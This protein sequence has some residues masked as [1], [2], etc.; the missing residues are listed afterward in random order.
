MTAGL[1]SGLGRF[2][3]DD[4]SSKW[5]SLS[6]AAVAVLCLGLVATGLVAVT[7]SGTRS[8]SAQ[9]PPPSADNRRGVHLRFAAQWESEMKRADDEVESAL[10]APG[11]DGLLQHHEE[12]AA[13]LAALRLASTDD[14]LLRDGLTKNGLNFVS[15]LANSQR[16]P[17]DATRTYASTYLRTLF[18]V[19][20]EHAIRI[21]KDVV[22]VLNRRNRSAPT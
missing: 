1:I 18:V 4:R 16:P 9:P 11:P 6:L 8:E 15:D 21:I 3:A 14:A 7:R 17:L 10:G 13:T 19:P 2:P 5:L 22:K 20:P 12:V